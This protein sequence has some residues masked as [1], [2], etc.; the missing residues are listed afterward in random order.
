MNQV[1]ICGNGKENYL[2]GFR[3]ISFALVVLIIIVISGLLVN[4]GDFI[5]SLVF[6]E[7]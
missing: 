7:S 3:V 2:V 5:F 1:V 4:V 6:N